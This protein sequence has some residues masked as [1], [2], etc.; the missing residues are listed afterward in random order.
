M[1]PFIPDFV[2][3][4][5]ALEMLR[6]KLCVTDKGCDAFRRCGF[7]AAVVEIVAV[8]EDQQRLDAPL[9]GAI[10]HLV[11]LRGNLQHTA[12]LFDTTPAGVIAQAHDAG[13]GQGVE[14]LVD[15]ARLSRQVSGH[16]QDERRFGMRQIRGQD[17]G[18]GALPRAG[19]AGFARRAWPE[20]GKDAQRT[21]PIRWSENAAQLARS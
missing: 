19:A 10:D 15:R 2:A 21:L 3:L 18:P 11:P 8:V 5:S 6:Q 17:A 20:G 1:I 16:A 9:H 13:R 4:Y 7:A 12:L 14:T